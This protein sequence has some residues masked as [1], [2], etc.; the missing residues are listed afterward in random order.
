MVYKQI[1]IFTFLLFLSFANAVNAVIVRTDIQEDFHQIVDTND[2]LNLSISLNK[3]IYGL[4]EDII[5]TVCL[6]NVG[7]KPIGIYKKLDWGA[8]SSLFLARLYPF[9][10]SLL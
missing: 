1:I 10:K 5:L 4:Q 8:F 2:G 6:K 7:K 9:W 3:A